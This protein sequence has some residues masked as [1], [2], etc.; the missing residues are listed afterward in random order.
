MTSDRARIGVD[1]GGT[2]TDLVLLVGGRVAAVGKALTTPADPSVAVAEG[3]ERLLAEVEPASVGEVVHGTTL[4]ANALIERKGARTA[5]LTTRGAR[6]ALAIRREHR[7]DLYDL[8]LE[9]P[10]PLVPRRRRWEVDERVLADGTVD[11]PLDE[12]QVRRVARRAGREGVEA[13]AVCFLHSYRHPEHELRA[14]EVLAEELPGVPVSASCDIVPELGEYVRASTT[15]A[16]AYVRPLMDRYLGT[17]ARRLGEAGLRAPLHLMLSTGGLATVE[18]GRRHPVRLTESGPAAGALSAAFAGAAAGE[19]DVLGFDMGG[20]TAKACLVEG[21]EP[22]LAREHEVARVYRFAPESGLPL[23][24]PVIDLI[25]IGAGGGSIARVDQFGLPKV[26]P[27]SAGAEPGPACYGRGGDQPTVTDADLLLGY[28]DPRFFLG[29]EMALNVDAARSAVGR[30]ASALGLDLAEAAAGVHRVVNESMAGAARMHAIERGRDLRRFAL[31]ATGGAGPLHAWGV[32][33]RL[34]IGRLVLPPSA[35]VA[36]AFGMLTAPPAFDFARSLPAALAGVQWSD[37]RSA[38]EAMRGEGAAQLAAAGVPAHQV[39]VA[40]SAD[41]RYRGQG[42]GVTVALGAGLGRR[43]AEQVR[44]A[45]EAAYLRLYGRRP[46]GVEPEVLTWRLRVSGPRP[47]LAAR[48]AG[49]PAPGPARKG[50][51]PVWS[52]ERRG[53]VEA[54]VWD[55][56]RLAP[57]A[58]LAGPAVVEER[59]SSAL[60]GVGGRGVVDEH[61][62]L[63]VEVPAS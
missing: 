47:T 52:E 63:R 54:D 59:E 39:A 61:G 16:N 42:E 29:G 49:A 1:I 24:V 55:R 19:R 40:L 44:E 27:E 13:L 9:L 17:L 46:P 36:S 14:A 37:V 21:G 28:L 60:I 30:L 23:R 12:A 15:V 33:R 35:G 43:P 7:Y 6:D 41:I 25:E 58:E 50:R 48:S 51:R 31:V 32:A 10:E 53:F 26:G 57:G 4:V 5:L 8:F 3:V 22:L 45:F 62:N 20:T 11:R 18:T 56:Y 2:F 34:G 38:M